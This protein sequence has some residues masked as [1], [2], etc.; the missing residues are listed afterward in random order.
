MPTLATARLALLHIDLV[1][2]EQLRRVRRRR[3]E[4]ELFKPL[5][6]VLERLPLV[7]V[8]YKDDPVAATVVRRSRCPEALLWKRACMSVASWA[9]W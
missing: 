4:I 5:L 9:R 3:V 2:H 7:H 6:Q 8:E 1:A